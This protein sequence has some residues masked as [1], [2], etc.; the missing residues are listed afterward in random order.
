MSVVG[1]TTSSNTGLTEISDAAQRLPQGGKETAARCNPAT[2]ISLGKGRC[3]GEQDTKTYLPVL[4]MALTAATAAVAHGTSG[5]ALPR[6]HRGSGQGA[7]REPRRGS[8]TGWPGAPGG[9]QRTLPNGQACAKFPRSS[10]PRSAHAGMKEHE[11]KGQQAPVRSRNR[12][13]EQLA[14]P[15]RS[16]SRPQ[17]GLR[18]PAAQ[19]WEQ[20]CL[21]PQ[22]LHQRLPIS[23]CPA[24]TPFCSQAL[25]LA[26]AQSR[27]TGLTKRVV[28]PLPTGGRREAFLPA[29]RARWFGEGLPSLSS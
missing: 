6:K 20:R 16:T 17:E 9:D 1:Q 5:P 13:W 28:C 24:E 8:S 18:G 29:I 15:P 25:T 23:G 12:R 14:K 2:F 10:S 26:P 22:H 4:P 7:G 11:S 27:A 19:G 3:P 21:N